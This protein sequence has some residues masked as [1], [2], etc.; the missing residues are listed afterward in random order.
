LSW[1]IIR[2]A[3]FGICTMCWISIWMRRSRAV[4][5]GS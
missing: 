2:R 5:G 3:G 4:R 1:G